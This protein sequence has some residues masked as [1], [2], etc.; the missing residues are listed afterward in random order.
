MSIKFG[1][2][3]GE[4]GGRKTAV[5]V[6]IQFYVILFECDCVWLI[7]FIEHSEHIQYSI[8]NISIVIYLVYAVLI[9]YTSILELICTALYIQILYLYTDTN[10]LQCISIVHYNMLLCLP[11]T[12]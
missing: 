6:K 2:L 8:F 9:I 3:F 4:P 5:Y 10:V 12:K 11:H 7:T 1:S